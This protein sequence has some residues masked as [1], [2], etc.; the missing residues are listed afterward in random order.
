MEAEHGS[1]FTNPETWVTL[2][3]LVVVIFG[4]FKV[5]KG[6]S[7]ALDKRAGKISNEL[8]EA[9]RLREEAQELVNSR[10]WTALATWKPR[11][12]RK[13]GLMWLKLPLRQPLQW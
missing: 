13:F 1:F 9:Q 3:F 4:G 8:D 12:L 11:L 5:V 10:P 2:A 7:A 6:I